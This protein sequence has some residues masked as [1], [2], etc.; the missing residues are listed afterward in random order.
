MLQI[1]DVPCLQGKSK[2][3]ETRR[4][5]GPAFGQS[6]LQIGD[7]ACLQGKPKKGETGR[8]DGQLFGQSI[9]CFNYIC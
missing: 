2:K 1:G 5:D 8:V 9:F 4:V 3:G 7:V 6:M